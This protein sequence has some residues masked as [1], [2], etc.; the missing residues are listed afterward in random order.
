QGALPLSR[1]MLEA[2]AED[3]DLDSAEGRAHFAA[4]ARAL[5]QAL[6]ERGLLRQQL[7]ADIA[8]RAGLDATALLHS[9]GERHP[10]TAAPRR[11]APAHRATFAPRTSA[12][13]NALQAHARN[14]ARLLLHDAA[15]W[16]ELSEDERGELCSTPGDW[17]NALRWLEQQF[18]EYGSQNT[19]ALLRASEPDRALHGK[20]S[21]LLASDTL[22]ADTPPS[23]HELRLGVIQVRIEL[24][25][26][27]R[28]AHQDAPDSNAYRDA[29]RQL[30]Q[31]RQQ[32]ES[33]RRTPGTAPAPA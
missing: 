19:A 30:T 17:G 14:V 24:A 18:V 5:W 23:T 20:L 11:P 6:P 22:A 33:L 31:L 28:R 29:L 1:F 7:L 21:S 15:L 3:C 32:L 12:Q 8:A 9:W 27:R 16:D 26:E 2:A 13:G 4:N 25:G 10:H